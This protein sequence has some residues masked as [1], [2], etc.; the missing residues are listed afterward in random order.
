MDGYGIDVDHASELIVVVVG[1][2]PGDKI[3]IT[4]LQGETLAE[5]TTRA[6]HQGRRQRP[7]TRNRP[8]RRVSPKFC[9]TE[10][11]PVS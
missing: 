6:R 8:N 3:T 5:H 7:T 1:E 10:P 2:Q 9:H 11:P 4:D